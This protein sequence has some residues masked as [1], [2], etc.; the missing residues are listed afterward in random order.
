MV[1]IGKLSFSSKTGW[2]RAKFW[3]FQVVI[4]SGMEFAVPLASLAGPSSN[5]QF[6]ILRM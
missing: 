5:T 4:V 3:T 2:V 1:A 6:D